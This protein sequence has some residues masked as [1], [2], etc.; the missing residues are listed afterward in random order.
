MHTYVCTK[1]ITPRNCPCGCEHILCNPL[2][3]CTIA[4][5]VHSQ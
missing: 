5:Y 1:D 3:Q 4:S 2:S